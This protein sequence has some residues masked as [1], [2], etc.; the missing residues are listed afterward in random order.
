MNQSVI[1]CILSNREQTRFYNGS[2]WG[3]KRIDS[4]REFFDKEE[5]VYW[6]DHAFSKF[7]KETFNTLLTVEINTTVREIKFLD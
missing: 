7:H 6:R 1:R 3:T 5:A 4:A 2:T